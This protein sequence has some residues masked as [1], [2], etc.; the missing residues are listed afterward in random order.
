M[1]KS[2]FVT[3][4]VC[5]LHN[6]HRFVTSLGLCMATFQRQLRML[7]WFLT[8]CCNLLSF[9]YPMKKHL[10]V[11]YHFVINLLSICYPSYFL[12]G[13]NMTQNPDD[14]IKFLLVP[15]DAATSCMELAYDSI[16]GR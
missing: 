11:L 1:S 14:E 15:G 4:R 10:Q 13:M 12:P 9:C 8:M 5:D 3:R 16:I 7:S 2:T 6:K